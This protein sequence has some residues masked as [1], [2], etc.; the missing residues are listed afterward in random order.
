MMTQIATIAERYT[1]SG[2]SPQLALQPPGIDDAVAI[3]S[4]EAKQKQEGIAEVSRTDAERLVLSV[5]NLPLAI[6]QAASYMRISGSSAQEVL[7]L[8]E[9]DEVSEVSEGNGKCLDSTID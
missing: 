3:L 2:G 1:A 7:D 5:G 4:A 9:S 6:G 8:Y